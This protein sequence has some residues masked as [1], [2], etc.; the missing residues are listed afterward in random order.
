MEAL[1]R[2]DNLISCPVRRSGNRFSFIHKSLQEFFAALHIARQVNER[3]LEVDSGSP[4]PDEP[5]LIG[6]KLLTEE[7][8]VLKFLANL[9]DPRV[10]LFRRRSPAA[11]DDD[12]EATQPL[13]RGLFELVYA[14]RR[15]AHESKDSR[16]ELGA[17]DKQVVRCA[18]N[19]L[20]VLV[21]AGVSMAGACLPA[22]LPACF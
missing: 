21:C 6:E 12:S 4:A 10:W 20:S 19:A 5:F 16:Q 11:A 3:Q 2:P 9:V 14:S 1:F 22:C 17:S 13:G 15:V 18:A 7:V 8:A